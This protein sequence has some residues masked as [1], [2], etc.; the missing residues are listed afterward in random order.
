MS[1]KQITV[2]KCRPYFVCLL[3][4][5]YGWNLSQAIP[6]LE[7]DA[8]S[9][10][11]KESDSLLI[12]SFQNS[13]SEFPWIRYY[14]DRSVTELEVRHAVL[15]DLQS[16]TSKRALFYLKNSNGI[17][18]RSASSLM[19]SSV[20]TAEQKLA[21]LKKEVQLTHG[22][23]VQNYTFAEEMAESL[24]ENLLKTLQKDFPPLY[25]FLSFS[26]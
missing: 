17:S 8:S 1:N 10:K 2:D 7:L 16:P 13:I 18:L 24:Y 3:G 11:T 23:S 9:A 22:L 14:S 20:P 4:E 5:R 19:D 6:N 15:N 12:K 25:V 21:N 26:C